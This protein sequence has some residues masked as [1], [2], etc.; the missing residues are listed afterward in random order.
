MTT[1]TTR[2]WAASMLALS[3]A[4]APSTSA[5]GLE[6]SGMQATHTCC[7]RL[8]AA[9]PASQPGTAATTAS[10]RHVRQERALSEQPPAD[11]TAAASKPAV[12]RVRA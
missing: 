9:P 8:A 10:R 4:N 12:H 11:A 5:L 1:S 2:P 6:E 3:R 7:G